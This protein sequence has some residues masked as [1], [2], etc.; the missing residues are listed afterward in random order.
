MGFFKGCWVKLGLLLS[1]PNTHRPQTKVYLPLVRRTA[2]AQSSS[3][4]QMEMKLDWRS[5]YTKWRHKTLL[6]Y[7]VSATAESARPQKKSIW[8]KKR[9]SCGGTRPF[10]VRTGTKVA[11][12]N[13]EI[14]P[15][16]HRD[17]KSRWICLKAVWHYW[18]TQSCTVV[19]FF[20]SRG[21]KK[22]TLRWR[23]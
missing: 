2:R 20:Y 11:K 23:E 16:P 6:V 9:H 3:C 22:N 10:T 1:P 18:R 19:F 8:M 14:F 4:S 21:K 5:I 7:P 15:L 12:N 17:R 13:S